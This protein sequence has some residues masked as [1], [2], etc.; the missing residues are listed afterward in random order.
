M[1]LKKVEERSVYTRESS[2]AEGWEAVWCESR[3]CRA[4]GLYVTEDGARNLTCV[5]LLPS[6]IAKTTAAEWGEKDL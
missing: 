4:G 1:C 6:V 5:C 2:G 3:V